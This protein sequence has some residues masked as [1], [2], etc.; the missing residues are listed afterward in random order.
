MP[1]KTWV[2]TTSVYSLDSNWLPISI[3]N[4]VYKWT[5]S[6]SGTGEFYLELIGGGDPGLAEP[7]NVQANGTNLTAGTAGSLAAS[8]WDYAD[9]DTLGYS[10]IYVRLS[11]DADPD[12]KSRD[13]V[14][15]TAP[16]IAG[17]DVRIPAGS[18]AIAGG[19]Y[20]GTAIADF[21]VE[22]GHTGT[23]G[24]STVPLIIDPNAFRFSGSGLSYID[25]FTA[26]ISPEVFNTAAAGTGLRGLYLT[27]SALS[28]LN[29]V[30]GFVGMASRSGEISALTT[31]R[32]I[33]STAD[34]WIG[35]GC[36]LTTLLQEAGSTVVRCAAT[37]ITSYGGE[38]RTKESGTVTTV[39]ARGGT[40]Y[41]ESTGT[42]TNVNADGGTVNGLTSGASRTWTN[43][44]VNPGGSAIYD[45]AIVTVT[46]KVA[47]DYP[48]RIT[49]TK[50]S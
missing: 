36:T 35:E 10:T 50:P 22:E 1:T 4:G 27:G 41:L 5:A 24:S 2:G 11:D 40:I 17:D 33:G 18:G 45:P 13:F 34:L 46:T 23:I 14:T 6:G 47:P 30:N 3:R 31:A 15:F 43:L 9:N 16:P 28:T 37:T 21:V 38:V 29:V 12:S 49:A 19:D 26:A 32:T 42:V 39:N 48:V 8:R 7:T 25:L 20:S 44:K